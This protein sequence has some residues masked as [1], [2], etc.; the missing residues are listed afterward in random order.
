[1]IKRLAFSAVAAVSLTVTLAPIAAAEEAPRW[2]RTLTD[3]VG[4]PFQIA[5]N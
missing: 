2:S 5:V 4:A 1:M 3:R